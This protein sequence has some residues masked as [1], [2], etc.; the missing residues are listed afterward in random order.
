VTLI[1]FIHIILA[2][3]LNL[4]YLGDLQGQAPGWVYWVIAICVFNYQTLDA[5][6]GK[7]ARRTKGGSALGELFDHGCDAISATVSTSVVF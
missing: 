1:A 2:F 5:L 4:Y 7:Q 3:G 6:D